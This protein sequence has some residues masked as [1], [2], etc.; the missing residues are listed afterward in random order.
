MKPLDDIDRRILA[1]LQRDGRITFGQ[2]AREVALSARP[3]LERVRRLER[4][5]VIGGYTAL[6]DARSAGLVTVIAEVTLRDQGRQ[7]QAQ[8]ERRVA[9]CPEVVACHLI[10]G[11][12]DYVVRFA[13]PSLEHYRVLT[14]SW[15]DD[16]VM[17]V[18]RVASMPELK[19]IKEFRGYPVRGA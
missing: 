4:D 9:D 12:F 5:G 2:L 1:A 18:A 8:F 16:P 10:S 7:V 17:G 15:I 6:L 11:S 3:T 19:T 14:A 13:C